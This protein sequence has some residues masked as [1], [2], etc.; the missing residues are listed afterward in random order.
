MTRALFWIALLVL[1]VFAVRSKIGK[2]NKGK[3]SAAKA[4]A[5][6]EGE[7]MACCAHCHVYFPQSEAVR[8]DGRAYCSQA[9]LGLPEQ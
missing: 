5:L 2:L 9:H 6:E 4:E 8:Q 1:I 7:P 3:R